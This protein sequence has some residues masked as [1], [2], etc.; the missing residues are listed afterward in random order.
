MRIALTCNGPGEFA[1]WIRPLVAA[2]YEINPS[3]DVSVFFVPDDYAT[4]REPEVARELFPTMRVFGSREYLRF[5]FGRSVP[6]APKTVDVVQYLGGDLGHAVRLHSRL[7]GRARSYKFWSKSYNKTFERVYTLDENNE[8]SL[9]RQ[10]LN[11]DGME[12]CRQSR[13]GRRAG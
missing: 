9:H 3:T 13:G 12:R 1:G 10:G 7:G 8:A 11:P 4:G 6:N 2:L 5:A